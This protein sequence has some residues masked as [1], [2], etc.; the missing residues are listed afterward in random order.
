MSVFYSHYDLD[1][2]NTKAVTFDGPGTLE[3]MKKLAGNENSTNKL[4]FEEEELD[5]TSYLNP[6]NIVNCSNT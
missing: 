4:K 2:P 1:F 6:P 3:M 5:I